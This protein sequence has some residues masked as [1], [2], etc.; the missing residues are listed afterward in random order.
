MKSKI[1]ELAM[2][3][4]NAEDSTQEAFDCAAFAAWHSLDGGQKEVLRQLLFNGPVW[5]GDICSKSARDDL[6]D[7][8][9]AVRCCFKGE[10][11]HTAA[12]YRAYT[13]WHAGNPKTTDSAHG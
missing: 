9:L 5:D 12:S 8:T 2:R 13:I 7:F 3:V 10:Q 6:I 4:L 11:G 1:I